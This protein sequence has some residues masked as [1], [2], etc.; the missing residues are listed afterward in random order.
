MGISSDPQ[1]V[2]LGIVILAAAVLDRL[3]QPA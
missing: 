3:K 2:V 1:K